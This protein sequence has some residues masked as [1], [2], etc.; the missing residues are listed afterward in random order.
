M[1]WRLLL[2]SSLSAGRVRQ[3]SCLNSGKRESQLEL[4]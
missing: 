3:R 1:L 2:Y 4:T